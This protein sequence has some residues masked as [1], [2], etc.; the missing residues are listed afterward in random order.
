VIARPQLMS[1]IRRSVGL[2]CLRE[3]TTMRSG[4]L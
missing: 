1:L 4:Y 3:K 2:D